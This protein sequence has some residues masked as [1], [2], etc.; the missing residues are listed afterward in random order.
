MYTDFGSSYDFG[1][2]GRSTTTGYPQGMTRRYCAP[3][4]IECGSR[5]SKSDVFSLGCVFIEI[6]LALADDAEHDQIYRGLYHEVVYSHPNGIP[7]PY[8]ASLKFRIL[9]PLRAVV[10]TMMRRDPS[11]RHSACAVA[12]LIFTDESF[13]KSPDLC[14]E[15]S[16][17]SISGDNNE[18]LR[19]LPA[20]I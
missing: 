7:L 9:A 6:Y 11:L 20:T 5:N 16:E 8:G 1:D 13:S 18:L 19:L 14:I 17:F 12:N 2:A 4:V 15:C 10:P 3:E